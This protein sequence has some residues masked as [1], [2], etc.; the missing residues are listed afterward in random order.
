MGRRHVGGQ[1]DRSFATRQEVVRDGQALSG[2][3]PTL[4]GDYPALGMALEQALADTLATFPSVERPWRTAIS[5][6][7]IDET[8]S[9]PDFRHAGLRY[10]DTFYSASLLKVA[11]M[12]AAFGLLRSANTVAAEVSASA[13]FFNQLKLQFDR[14]VVRG[15]LA[16]LVSAENTCARFASSCSRSG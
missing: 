15:Q 16:M 1:V 12:Y 6:A 11:A 8:T 9:P 4:L 3:Y 10:G 13:D 14:E 2:P 7:A 5:I